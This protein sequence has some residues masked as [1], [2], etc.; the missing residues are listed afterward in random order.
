MNWTLQMATKHL[1]LTSAKLLMFCHQ[2]VLKPSAQKIGSV[3]I[4][5]VVVIIS[6]WTL[7]MQWAEMHYAT[8]ICVFNQNTEDIRCH[9]LFVTLIPLRHYVDISLSGKPYLYLDSE[10]VTCCLQLH[11]F[12]FLS[13]HITTVI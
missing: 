11:R 7:E 9:I 10:K 5:V 8:W 4:L 2:F 12:P 3:I 1:W 13:S 6:N